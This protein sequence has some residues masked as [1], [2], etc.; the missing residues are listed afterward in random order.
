MIQS[1]WCRH[2][3]ISYVSRSISET[4]TATV[5]VKLELSFSA[6]WTILCKDLKSN[7][8]GFKHVQKLRQQNKEAKVDF[9]M[10]VKKPGGR[11]ASF[12]W[13]RN[14]V[15][16]VRVP[17]AAPFAFIV[18]GKEEIRRGA[19]PRIVR[20]SYLRRHGEFPAPLLGLL[21]G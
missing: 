15:C 8:Y 7:P 11:I 13:M 1:F 16:R 2:K 19:G 17:I 14:S 5:F 10:W 6:I 9:C 20:R 12:F 3:K 4:T 21:G 18:D